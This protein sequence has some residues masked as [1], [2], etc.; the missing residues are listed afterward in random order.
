MVVVLRKHLQFFPQKRKEKYI[1]DQIFCILSINILNV[2]AIYKISKWHVSSLLDITEKA[3]GQEDKKRCNV[4]AAGEA[5]GEAPSIGIIAAAQRMQDTDFVL[6]NFLLEDNQIEAKHQTLKERYQNL[7]N[8]EREQNEE[9][10]Q[11]LLKQIEKSKTKMDNRKF[12]RSILEQEA[13]RAKV[14]Y[15]REVL[16]SQQ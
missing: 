5:L 8:D 13:H 9:R 3:R 6:Q 1:S 16:R 4:E 11:K 12:R 14:Q 15:E 7:Q 10:K 2:E